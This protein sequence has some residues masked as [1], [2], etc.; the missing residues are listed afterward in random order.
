[1]PIRGAETIFIPN[2]CKYYGDEMT[3]QTNN[4]RVSE[5]IAF[6]K[7]NCM[8]CKGRSRLRPIEQEQGNVQTGLKN[9]VEFY[10]DEFNHSRREDAPAERINDAIENKRLCMDLIEECNA[11][12]K[13]IDRVNRGLNK[14]RK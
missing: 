12:D 9:M 13:E 10:Q 11:C 3:E 5:R 1:M 14:I 6:V 8:L 4:E 7:R 2:S